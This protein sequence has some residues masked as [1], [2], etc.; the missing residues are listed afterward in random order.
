MKPIKIIEEK[1]SRILF[2]FG[3]CKTFL[4]DTQL[5]SFVKDKDDCI[6]LKHNLLHGKKK[7]L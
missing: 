6:K 5:N 2:N 1:Q 3:M 7:M 4:G